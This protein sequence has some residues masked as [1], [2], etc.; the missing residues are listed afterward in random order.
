[1]A[2]RQPGPPKSTPYSI[3][4]PL[5]STIRTVRTMTA[6]RVSS[7]ISSDP[8]SAGVVVRAHMVLK[9]FETGR[10]VCRVI[11]SIEVPPLEVD[12]RYV[13]NPEQAAELIAAVRQ[14]ST[15]GEQMAGFFG[16]LYYAAMRPS[17]I[18]ALRK[19]DC[20]LPETG[21]GELVL[22]GSRPEVGAGW[23]DDGQSFDQ[24]GLKHR[25]RRATLS[26]PIPPILTVMLREHIEQFG[27]AADGRLFR[28]ARGGRVR[29]TEYC[30]LWDAAR[31]MALSPEE[32]ESPLADVP[33]SLRHAGVSPWINLGVDPVEVARRAGH[34]L[35]V[36][37]RFYAK[38]LRGQQ[39]RANELIERGLSGG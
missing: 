15:R 20:R 17:E 25:D 3:V 10:P 18:A 8:A 29:S 38:I 28:A 22:G 6:A 39:S 12:F 13:P 35:T 34:S 7:G 24:R 32:A 27:V 4:I 36:L 5:V 14:L 31:V 26:V 9:R 19:A 16:C 21:R 30:E 1:M 33:Y 37:F 2:Q 11:T 23:T